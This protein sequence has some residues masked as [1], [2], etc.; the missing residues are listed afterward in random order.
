MYIYIRFS[1]LT[2][3]ISAVI[4]RPPINFAFPDAMV[5]NCPSSW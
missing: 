2:T 5:Q 3:A 4:G 1:A